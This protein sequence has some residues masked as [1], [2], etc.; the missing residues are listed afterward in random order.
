LFQ[1]FGQKLILVGWGVLFAFINEE[2]KKELMD[3]IDTKNPKRVTS[4]SVK[5]LRDYLLAK[6]EDADFE[7]F[8]NAKLDNILASFYLE[9]RNKDG[10]MYKKTILMSYRQGLQRHL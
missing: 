7:S 2:Q 1:N 4:T 6:G 10:E 8:D 5:L 9:V 3:K